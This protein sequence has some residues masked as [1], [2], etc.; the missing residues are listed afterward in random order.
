MCKN[1]FSVSLTSPLI[2][3]RL[4]IVLLVLWLV[5]GMIGWFIHAILVS[6]LAAT[7]GYLVWLGWQVGRWRIDVNRAR[8]QL[9]MTSDYWCDAFASLSDAVVMV[10]DRGHIDWSNQVAEQL[11]GLRYPQDQGQPLTDWIKNPTFITFYKKGDYR[12]PLAMTSPVDRHKK[13]QCSITGFAQGN[14]LLLAKDVTNTYRLQK[15]RTDFI[16]NV[17]HELRTPLTVITGYLETLLAIDREDKLRTDRAVNQMLSQARRMENLIRDLILLSRLEHVPDTTEQARI[18]LRPLLES[19]RDDVLSAVSTTTHTTKRI[20]IECDDSLQLIGNVDELRSAF[21]NLVMNAA[22]YTDDGGYIKLCWYTGEGSGRINNEGAIFSVT[23]DGIGI[24]PKHWRRLSE[25]FYRVDKSRSMNT[26][27]TGLGLAIT[28]HVL[29]RHQARLRIDSRYG[30][31]STFSC[32]FPVE[33]VY[34]GP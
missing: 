34:R 5:A 27:G 18:V 14:R 21:S 8:Q 6:V 26:G 9:Q 24:E 33:R 32:V 13:L 1:F 11:L 25:R 10:N 15:M 2:W 31:G 17:S 4:A 23:D 29:L 7:L 30:E 16:A 20:D 19:I 22:R 28:K 12:K 3:Q